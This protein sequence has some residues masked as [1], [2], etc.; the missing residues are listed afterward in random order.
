[1]ASTGGGV[2]GKLLYFDSTD[3]SFYADSHVTIL[4]NSK[5][6][7]ITKFL[8]F[9]FSTRYE[10]INQTLVKGSTNQTELQCNYLLNYEL[11]LPRTEELLAI[12]DYLEKRLSA[13]N[14]KIETINKLIDAY[15]RLKRS[16][17]NE[18]IT[19][20]IKT[21]SYAGSRNTHTG[22]IYNEIPLPLRA[23]RRLRL[24]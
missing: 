13:I 11:P 4:R 23:R 15:K 14:V 7:L 17:I 5:N 12:V 16:L 20:N 24:S 2:L 6:P 3:S 18:V 9:Y 1:M 10:E 22:R 21:N 19:G 8:F